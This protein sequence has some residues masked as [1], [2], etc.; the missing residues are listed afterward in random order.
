[1]CFKKFFRDLLC[2]LLVLGLVLPFSLAQ[3]NDGERKARIITQVAKPAECLSRVAIQ[4]IDGKEKFVSPQA[5]ELSPGRHSLSGSVAVDTTF[6]KVVR[7]RQDVRVAPLEADFEAG[8]TYWIGY[9][10]SSKNR[11]DWKLVI[12]KVE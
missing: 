7:G 5:F 2:A 10:H 9:D 12:W 3:A 6:C 1:M 11:E 4:K 8:K